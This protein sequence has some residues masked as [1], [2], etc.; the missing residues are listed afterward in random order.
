MKLPHVN[1]VKYRKL[2]F[3]I[4]LLLTIPGIIGIILCMIEFGA[5]LKPGIDFTGG[6]ILQ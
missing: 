3:G 4:S 2:W 5:P 1:I 6:S